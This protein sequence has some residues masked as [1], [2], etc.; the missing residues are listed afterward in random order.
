[1][2]SFDGDVPTS[3]DNNRVVVAASFGTLL[4]C[5][6]RRFLRQS[7]RSTSRSKASRAAPTTIATIAAVESFF[8][9]FPIGFGP[10]FF[11]GDEVGDGKNGLHDSDESIFWFFLWV[12][13]GLG[14]VLYS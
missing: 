4:G 13:S 8:D 2:S 11:D 7:K 14:M 12:C 6:R 10:E 5:R 9:F 1:M 3:A